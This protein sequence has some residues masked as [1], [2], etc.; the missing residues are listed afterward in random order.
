MIEATPRGQK[1]KR[2]KGTKQG[3]QGN[4]NSQLMKL[5]LAAGDRLILGAEMTLQRITRPHNALEIIGVPK[6]QTKPELHAVSGSNPAEV[7]RLR[8][9]QAEKIGQEE[10]VPGN[11]P[12]APDDGYYRLSLQRT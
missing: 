7:S 6:A 5:S 9:A 8:R 3:K 12:D 11:K 10:L 1:Q 4:Q 2:K